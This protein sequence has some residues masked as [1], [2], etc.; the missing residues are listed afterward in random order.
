MA[1]AVGSTTRSTLR[2]L[3]SRFT[4]SMT[5]S[6]PCAPVPMTRHVHFH[7]MFSSTDNGVWPNVSRNFLDAFFFRRRMSPQSTTTSYS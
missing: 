2:S 4:S 5:G 6:R 1:S 7:G 3:A